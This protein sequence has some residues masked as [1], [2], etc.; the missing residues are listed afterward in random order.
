MTD[1]WLKANE[2]LGNEL[3]M[4]SRGKQVNHRVSKVSAEILESSLEWLIN[5]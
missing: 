5:V 2:N 3:L 4:K 1:A